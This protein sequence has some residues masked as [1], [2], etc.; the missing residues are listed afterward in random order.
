LN[1]IIKKMMSET[2]DTKFSRTWTSLNYEDLEVFSEHLSE[3]IVR[4]CAEI[5][6][7]EEHDPYECILKHFGVEK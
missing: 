6:L 5:A 7:R 1:E 4:K 3:S 2:L